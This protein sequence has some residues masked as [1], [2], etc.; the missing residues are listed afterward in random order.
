[1]KK[2]TV[3]EMTTVGSCIGYREATGKAKNRLHGSC[4]DYRQHDFQDA[5]VAKT[6]TQILLPPQGEILDEQKKGQGSARA[7]VSEDKNRP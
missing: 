4:D 6:A 2:N 3:A 1:M 5:T 7:P